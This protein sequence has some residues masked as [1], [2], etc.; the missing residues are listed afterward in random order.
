MDTPP[1]SL[2]P[3]PRAGWNR[4]HGLD[5][6]KHDFRQ[7]SG[8]CRPS[9][10]RIVPSGISP[11]KWL[12]ARRRAG[13]QRLCRATTPCSNSQAT[14]QTAEL[15]HPGHTPRQ[16]T[17][18]DGRHEQAN[19]HQLRHDELVPLHCRAAQARF[20]ADLAGQGGG[21]GWRRRTAGPVALRCSPAPRSSSALTITVLLRPPLRQT[22]GMVASLLEMANQDCAVR[23][24][25]TLCRRQTL[26]VQIDT[27]ASRMWALRS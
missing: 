17:W 3:P 24:C 22:T 23:D 7:C 19:T 4:S 10:V 25:T 8:A 26:A 20:A 14:R 13:S 27:K 16:S 21:L 15:R 6:G 5:G 1:R 9:P 2:L 18:S 12:A 11:Y